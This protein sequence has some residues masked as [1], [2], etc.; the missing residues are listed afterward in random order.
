MRPSGRQVDELRPTEIK[1]NFTCHAE[2]SVLICTGGTQV[3]CTASVED[4]V[5]PFL[6][7]KGQGWVTAEYGMLPRSTGSRM[8][9]EAARGK[10]GGRWNTEKRRKD[11]LVRSEILVRRIPQGFVFFECTHATTYV[12]AW[13]RILEMY[14]AVVAHNVFVQGV[15]VLAVHNGKGPVLCKNT[16]ANFQRGE[17]PTEQDHALA[18]GQCRIKVL[19]SLYAVQFGEVPI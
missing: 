11:T 4:R 10:Q 14:L 7:G 3:L 18:L 2:G 1:R 17:M 19:E 8:G 6:R 12:G 13:D 5:P 16:A 15:L 9:R